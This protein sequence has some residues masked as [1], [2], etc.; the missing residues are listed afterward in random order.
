MKKNYMLLPLLVAL[1][2]MVVNKKVSADENIPYVA[3]HYNR[4]G[5]ESGLTVSSSFKESAE[6][7]IAENGY[8]MKGGHFAGY[9]CDTPDGT[10]KRYYPGDKVYLKADKKNVVLEL[11]AQW[12]ADDITVIFDYNA[13]YCIHPERLEKGDLGKSFEEDRMVLRTGD[14]YV[15]PEPAMPGYDFIGWSFRE[16]KNGN[17]YY[18]NYCSKGMICSLPYEHTLYAVWQPQ[19]YMVDFDFNFSVDGTNP[20]PME[21]FEN[22]LSSDTYRVRYG[23]EYYILPTPSMRGYVFL[24]W[25]IKGNESTEQRKVT[26]TTVCERLQDHVLKSLWTPQTVTVTFNALNGEEAKVV[27]AVYGRKIER[28]PE[29]ADNPGYLFIG[30]NSEITGNGRWYGMNDVSDFISDTVL[31]AIYEPESFEISL[32]YNLSWKRE[33][34]NAKE[35]YINSV[36]V[37]FGEGFPVLPKPSRE[38]Y[39][40]TGWYLTDKN[41]NALSRVSEVTLVD[42]RCRN[43]LKAGWVRELVRIV[44]DY[45]NIGDSDPDNSL[46]D[47][48]YTSRFDP[49]EI[50]Y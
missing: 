26:E 14:I 35:T 44:Y 4:N 40:F 46:P 30:W 2:L 6:F 20:T 13:D 16:M 28:F 15:L 36:T 27:E 42:E 49:K 25:Y 1:F 7:V 31:Y 21:Y 48:K 39:R 17:G 9:W 45:N 34:V 5:A 50:I 11:Y 10:G 47:T 37:N 19:E 41:G 32:D 43:G 18:G 23:N 12:E 3:V 22:R 24:G 8:S 33:A 38:G 29:H